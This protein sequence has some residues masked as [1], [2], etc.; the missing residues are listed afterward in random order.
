[1]QPLSNLQLI[2]FPL[3]N[4]Q[5][6]LLA[7]Y[8]GVKSVPFSI[9]R[10]FMIHAKEECHRGKHAHKECNQLLVSLTGKCSVLCDD[11]KAKKEIA[12]ESPS[13]GLLIPKT[14]WA[15]Q[16]YEKDSV[17]MVLTDQLYD[18]ND[19]IRDYSDFLKY[20]GIS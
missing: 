17:L 1:M 12:L 14:I 13:K 19:Y 5:D 2:N 9:Q 20:R 15:E 18:P 6:S 3:F 7:I 8:E 11:G 10:V 4:E 16:Y